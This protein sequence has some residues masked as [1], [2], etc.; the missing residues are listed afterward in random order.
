MTSKFYVFAVILLL[1]AGILKTSGQGALKDDSGYDFYTHPDKGIDVPFASVTSADGFTFVTGSS[2]DYESAAG[3][4]QVIC[5]D[6]NGSLVWEKQLP[7]VTYSTEYGLAIALDNNG[8]VIVSGVKWNG[9]DMDMLTLKLNASDG[10]TIWQALYAGDNDFMDVPDEVTTDASGNIAITGI[11][12]TGSNTSWLTLKYNSSGSLLW[13]KVLEN[14]LTD[15]YIEP[16]DIHIS[17]DGSIGVTGYHGNSEYFQCYYTIVYS[18]TGDVIWSDLYEPEGSEQINSYAN[19]ITSDEE[20]NWYVTGILNTVDP[21]M[22]TLKYSQDGNLLWENTAEGELSQALGIENGDGVV[23]VGGRH[24]GDWVDDGTLLISYN[25]DGTENWVQATNDLI[26][27]RPAL[28]TLDASGSPVIS[29]WGYDGGTFDNRLK[30]IRYDVDGNVTDEWSFNIAN[31]GLGGFNEYMQ[32]AVDATGNFYMMF[33]SF[34]TDLGNTFEVA[35]AEFGED[36]FSWDF[37]FTKGG[38][39][40]IELLSTYKDAQN[41]TYLSGMYDSIIGT[42][43]YLVY[44]VSKYNATGSLEWE[45]SF[46]ALNDNAANGIQLRVADN[47]D[48][49]VYLGADFEGPTRIKKFDTH[50]ELQWEIEEMPGTIIYDEFTVD[51]AGNFILVGSGEEEG[52]KK[53]F[54]RKIASSGEVMWTAYDNRPEYSD[55][56]HSVSGVTTDAAGNI[57]LTG[58]AGTGG[59]ISQETDITVLKYSPSGELMWLASFPEEGMNTVGTSVYVSLTGDI[60]VNGY[61]EDRSNG[62]QQMLVM[63]LNQSGE[64]VWK[65]NYMESGRRVSSYKTVQLSNGDIIIPGF[66]VIEGVNNKV[67]MVK[68]DQDGN[69]VDVFETEYNRFYRDVHVDASDNFYLYTQMAS[70]PY[71]LRPYFSA[72]AMPLGTLVKLTRDGVMTEELYYGPE[73]SDFYPCMLL[74]MSDGRLVLSGRIMNEMAQFSGMFFYESEHV[75]VGIKDPVI[76]DAKMTGQIYPNPANGFTILPITLEGGSDVTIEVL[77]V[78]GRLVMIPYSGF[79]SSGDNRVKIDVAGLEKGMYIYNVKC[80]AVKETGKFV[81]E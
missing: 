53:F 72:G 50:G 75:A 62:Q 59:W 56:L 15:S 81:V 57:Y 13:T 6:S 49:Y 25:Y 24:F 70:S 1:F 43:L 51:N 55:E 74:P 77:D 11:T 36:G 61:T 66:S 31:I 79:M 44:I 32:L 5:I 54:T 60:F 67:I 47:G 21:R 26:D 38:A 78:S 48:S 52:V 28:L 10:A 45:Q 35:K 23:Y 18:E 3:L 69:L 7:A 16:K 30:T 9:H 68:Y 40:A 71:P 80:G 2:A 39:S 29:A 14:N 64:Q 19:G 17:A 76:T 27:V 41:N 42:N 73:L 58:K 34:Y 8:D 22:H 63:R 37:R 4:F 46:S 65:Q 33:N 20:G 12:Y